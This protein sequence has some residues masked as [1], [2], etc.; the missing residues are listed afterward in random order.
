MHPGQIYDC[1]QA[2]ANKLLILYKTAYLQVTG[3]TFEAVARIVQLECFFKYERI[4]LQLLR[5]ILVCK[6][7]TYTFHYGVM[8]DEEERRKERTKSIICK[9]QFS[10]S[11]QRDFSSSVVHTWIARYTYFQ[12]IGILRC[13]LLIQARM[14]IYPMYR[15]PF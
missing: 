4:H 3:C 8:T 15:K 10:N 12:F 6:M 14:P 2:L 11:D 1:K 5:S 9:V 13:F 7:F